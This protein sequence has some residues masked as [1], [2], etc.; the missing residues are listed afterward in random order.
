M[1]L[2]TQLI[3]FMTNEYFISTIH[4]FRAGR[5]GNARSSLDRYWDSSE[6]THGAGGMAMIF[7]ESAAEWARLR[8]VQQVGN[9]LDR[10]VG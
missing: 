6:F 7:F 9:F 1:I 5:S 10:Q 2:L 4:G 3:A 8:I